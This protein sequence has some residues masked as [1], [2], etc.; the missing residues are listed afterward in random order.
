MN[1]IPNIRLNEINDISALN[2]E[3]K[4]NIISLSENYKTKLEFIN[5][6]KND[7]IIKLTNANKELINKNS[8]LT[9]LIK[10]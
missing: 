5:L 2:Q 6:E 4:N 7:E 1:N 9:S 3:L 8:Q 10:N